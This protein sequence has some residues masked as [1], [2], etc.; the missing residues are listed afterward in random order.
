MRPDM[1]SSPE[2][3][4]DAGVRKVRIPMRQE[5]R[6]R[7]D[8]Q[9]DDIPGTLLDLSEGGMAIQCA[10]DTTVGSTLWF[11]FKAPGSSIEVTGKGCVVWIYPAGNAAGD[12]AELTALGLEFSSLEEADRREIV[13]I[14]R[15]EGG[16]KTELRRAEAEV[17][18]LR[19]LSEESESVSQRALEPTK[20]TSATSQSSAEEVDRRETAL[21][22]EIESL[23]AIIFELESRDAGNKLLET[24]LLWETAEFRVHQL[25]QSRA[26]LERELEEAREFIRK[27]LGLRL[28]SHKNEAYSPVLTEPT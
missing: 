15:G 9:S 22:R 25:R 4:S 19:L 16:L 26:A 10:V 7:S 6:V 17:A 5:I 24:T 21:C 23:K 20:Q 13:Q 3:S 8:G 27:T 18:R 11:G 1:N 12:E 14:V 2:S 28:G